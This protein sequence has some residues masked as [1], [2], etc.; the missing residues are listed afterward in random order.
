MNR[1]QWEAINGSP[2]KEPCKFCKADSATRLRLR[3]K[4]HKARKAISLAKSA[5]I[6]SGKVI[7][8]FERDEFTG[9]H[10]NVRT[11]AISGQGNRNV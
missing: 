10:Y 11:E 8:L 4:H 7:Q 2:V 3:V 9:W 6:E 5:A 1:T